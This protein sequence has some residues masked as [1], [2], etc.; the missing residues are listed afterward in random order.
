[1]KFQKKK[2]EEES[3]PKVVVVITVWSERKI[4]ALCLHA[5]VHTYVGLPLL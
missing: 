4:H 3:T 1:M 2:K 5:Y